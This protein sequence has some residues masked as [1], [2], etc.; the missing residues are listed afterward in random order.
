M[1]ERIVD[2]V[3]TGPDDVVLDVGAGVGGPA[4]RLATLTG[5]RVVAV[6]VLPELLAEARRRVRSSHREMRLSFLAGSA[7][8]LPLRTGSVDQVWSLGV[9]AH[10]SDHE[11]FAGE[12]FRV[13]R[14]GGVMVLTEAFWVGNQPPRFTTSAPKPWR[15]LQPEALTSALGTGGLVG[16][17]V[18]QWPGH[19]VRGALETTDPMLS[20]DLAE[21]RLVPMMVVAKRP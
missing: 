9:V 2:L 8:A 17:E 15:P 14:P 11:R 5:C 7:E 20:A 6:D 21:E 18:R 1:V 10:I 19:G 16:I 3:R 4:R 12:V 13:L